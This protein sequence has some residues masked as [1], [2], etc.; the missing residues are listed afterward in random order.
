M[1]TEGVSKLDLPKLTSLAERLKWA[2]RRLDL[3]QDQFAELV[4][5]TRVQIQKIENGR[6]LR[7]RNVGKLAEVGKVPAAWLQFGYAELEAL[8]QEAIQLAVDWNSLPEHTK[9]AIKAAVDASKDKGS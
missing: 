2:R 6:T 4:G 9:K 8:P 1:G 3:T 5:T 7:P